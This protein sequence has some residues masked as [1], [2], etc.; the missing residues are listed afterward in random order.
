MSYKLQTTKDYSIFC[1]SH[2]NRPIDSEDRK[3][4]LSRTR[5]SMIENGYLPCFPLMVK[6]NETGKYEILDGQGRFSIAKEL[7][8]PV[9]YVVV[10]NFEGS[11]A[12]LQTGKP[13]S[14]QNFV[15]HYAAN[16]DR[17]YQILKQWCKENHLPIMIGGSLLFGQ[18]AA[19]G[20]VCNYLKSG[21]FEVRDINFSNRVA[22][23]YNSIREVYQHAFKS[24]FL[25]ALSFVV[26]IDGF[27]DDRLIKK[28]KGWKCLHENCATANQ[29][30]EFI[31][32]IYNYHQEDKLPIRFEAEKIIKSRNI[33]KQA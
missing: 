30:I 20:N 1:T 12:D 16:G 8:L 19:S 18:G 6:K 7:D 13:W 27:N 32:K 24:S 25:H 26:R 31:E 23:I 2:D 5:K 21:T 14:N 17:N 22:R 9:Y 4:S 33:F 29:F 3:R 11:V 15:D 28:M 10:D